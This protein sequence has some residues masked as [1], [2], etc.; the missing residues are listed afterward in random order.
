MWIGFIIW[1]MFL[2]FFLIFFWILGILVIVFE[3][4]KV[5]CFKLFFFDCI[6]LLIIM[7]FVKNNEKVMIKKINFVIFVCIDKCII[8]EY[9]LLIEVYFNFIMLRNCVLEYL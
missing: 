8:V 3:V 5:F 7:I 2:L 4:I 1:L 9:L 6:K